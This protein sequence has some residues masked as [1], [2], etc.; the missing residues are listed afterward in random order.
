MILKDLSEIKR[1]RK[2]LKIT[3]EELAKRSGVSQALIAQIESGE[4]DPS[5]SKVNVIFEALESFSVKKEIKASGI[6]AKGVFGV[7]GNETVEEAANIM[8][9]YK[10]SQMP[11]FGNNNKI[12]GSISE[13]T[14][15][16]R[17]VFG[18]DLNRISIRKAEEVMD[19]AFPAVG[20]ETALHVISVLLEHNPAVIVS[21]KGEYVGI[22]TKADLLKFIK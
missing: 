10:I 2:E 7:N 19:D 15:V 16:N 20:K 4:V 17:L 18:E 5:Y 14:I 11:V 13:K 8:K 9:K 6:M 21:D 12:I 1:L 22:I 3:Q